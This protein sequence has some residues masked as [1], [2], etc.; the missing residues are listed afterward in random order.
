MVSK[1]AQG[2]FL[3]GKNMYASIFSLMQFMKN[4]RK[5]CIEDRELEIL[6]KCNQPQKILWLDKIGPLQFDRSN[7][8]LFKMS[9][10]LFISK[11]NLLDFLQFTKR[12]KLS[13]V[14][15]VIEISVS[16]LL[17]RNLIKMARQKTEILTID[18]IFPLVPFAI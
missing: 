12:R 4:D 10:I 14:S 9:I 8:V 3:K 2:F 5:N 11:R 17:Y 13:W 16:S 6:R 7:K 18:L 1:T 15:F